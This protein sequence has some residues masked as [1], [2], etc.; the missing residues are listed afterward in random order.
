MHTRRRKTK[1]LTVYP[2]TTSPNEKFE[3]NYP[4]IYCLF[5]FVVSPLLD[6]AAIVLTGG[7]GGLCVWSCFCNLVR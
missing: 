6:S 1:F 5:N 4:L 7:G 3:Y 2:T